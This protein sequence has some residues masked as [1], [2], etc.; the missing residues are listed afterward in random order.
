MKIV[1]LIIAHGSRE[2]EANQ[3]FF[4]FLERFRKTFPSR[5]VQGAFLELARPSIPEAIK[6]CIQDQATEIVVMPLMFFSGRH[7]KTDIPQL[8]QE[9]KSKY[10]KV[11]F[12]Y[13]G[14]LADHPM[15]LSLLDEKAKSLLKK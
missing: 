4:D 2:Q 12:H 9:A 8:I 10:P 1:Y 6:S 5:Q 7:V 14:P 15:L 11:D 3:A 13:T